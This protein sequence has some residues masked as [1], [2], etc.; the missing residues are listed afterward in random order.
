MKTIHRLLLSVGG[1]L[2][3]AIGALLYLR[4]AERKIHAQQKMTGVLV[5]KRYV[6]AGKRITADDVEERAIPE[7]YVQPMSLATLKGTPVHSRRGLTKG[8]QI[9]RMNVYEEGA[10]L[11]LAWV[12]APGQT[13]VSLQLPPPHAVGGHLVPGDR[14]DVL[15]V[16]DRQPGWEEPA[17]F[18]IFSR[19]RVLAVNEKIVDAPAPSAHENSRRE[20]PN[21]TILVTLELPLDLAARLALAEEKGRITLA[22]TSPLDLE[23]HLAP[24]VNLRGLKR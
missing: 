3:I 2:L 18:S 12:L 24:L 17:A 9:T 6:P 4:S 8:E 5:A 15:C 1:G 22:L 16:L 14:V 19:V 23:T 21:E 7:A 10:L 11:G 20:M 13:A